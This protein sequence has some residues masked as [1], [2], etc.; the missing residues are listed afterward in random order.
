LIAAFPDTR[1]AAVVREV[2]EAQHV[3]T[4]VGL[5]EAEALEVAEIIARHRL[6]IATGAVV[7]LARLDPQRRSRA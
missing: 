3:V 4:S 1:V 7:D 5:A 6:Q 2:R